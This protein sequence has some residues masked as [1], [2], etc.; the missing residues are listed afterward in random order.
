MVIHQV[1]MEVE[2]GQLLR[3]FFQARQSRFLHPTATDCA[4]GVLW[5]QA[6]NPG[7]Q[8]SIGRGILTNQALSSL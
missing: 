3:V 1:A 4:Q 8:I 7:V 6:K 2:K 5:G